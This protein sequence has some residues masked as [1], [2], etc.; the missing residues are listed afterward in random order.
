MTE[1]WK[2]NKRLILVP[3]TITIIGGMASTWTSQFG[4]YLVSLIVNMNEELSNRYYQSIADIEFNYLDYITSILVIVIGFISII[5]IIISDM[6]KDKVWINELKISHEKISESLNSKDNSTKEKRKNKIDKLSKVDSIKKIEA[7]IKRGKIVILI[8]KI[9]SAI[10]VFLLL[11]CVTYV[12]SIENEKTEFR[13]KM[14][15]I[16][17][18]C[19][20][21]DEIDEIRSLWISIEN[22]SDFLKINSRID[23]LYGKALYQNREYFD[24]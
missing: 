19:N 2:K 1:F 3:L 24:H 20:S 11:F 4:L 13:M 14:T 12:L 5:G 8:S 9:A 15:V 17:P 18:Y 7:D 23:S 10:Y 6:F 16:R 21:P 22:E